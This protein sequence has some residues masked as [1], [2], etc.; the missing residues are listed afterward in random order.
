ML[1]YGQ[2]KLQWTIMSVMFMAKTDKPEEALQIMISETS[3][4]Q[5]MLQ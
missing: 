1:H 4:K 5:P 2:L 3:P